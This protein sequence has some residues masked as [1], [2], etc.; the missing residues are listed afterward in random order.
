MLMTRVIPLAIAALLAAVPPPAAARTEAPCKAGTA[1]EFPARHAG[2]RTGSQ[3][4]G[5]LASVRGPDRDAMIDGLRREGIARVL[6]ATGDRGEV[7]ERVTEGLGRDGLR[8]GLTPDQKVLLVLSERKNGP[9]LMVGDGVSDAP[10]LAAADVGVAMGARGAA[11]SARDTVVL[12]QG[13]A[14]HPPRADVQGSAA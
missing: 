1:Q 13:L 3:V 10:A 8:A 6:L 14:T 12:G 11:A 9:V 7:A 5:D 2:A 4:M